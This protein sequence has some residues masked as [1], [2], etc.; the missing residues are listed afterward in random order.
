[1]V[2]E[3]DG[4]TVRDVGGGGGEGDGGVGEG[5]GGG[6]DRGG[7]RAGG[8]DA[9]GGP[10]GESSPASAASAAG[11]AESF[12]KIAVHFSATDAQLNRLRADSFMRARK[13]AQTTLMAW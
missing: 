5:G 2:L 4:E 1:M 9:G 7:V 3:A 8:S 11:V 13:A 6:G 12:R 10:S